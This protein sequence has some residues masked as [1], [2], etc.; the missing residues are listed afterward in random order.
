MAGR[1]GELRGQSPAIARPTRG[2]QALR[3]RDSTARTAAGPK[4]SGGL[5]GGVPPGQ[6]R[7]LSQRENSWSGSNPRTRQL[8]PREPLKDAGIEGNVTGLGDGQA[9]GDRLD[10]DPR[11]IKEPKAPLRQAR[12]PDPCVLRRSRASGR[13]RLL[14]RAPGSPGAAR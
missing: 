7:H 12:G 8:A 5:R 1:Y 2:L 14:A 11:V 4:R 10:A 13:R 9:R 3:S 6:H